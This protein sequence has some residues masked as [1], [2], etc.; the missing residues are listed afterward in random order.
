MVSYFDA[1]DEWILDSGCRFRMT[2]FKQFSFELNEFGGGNIVL[3][4]T[5]IVM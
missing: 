3:V 5:N 1:N 4:M 2:P